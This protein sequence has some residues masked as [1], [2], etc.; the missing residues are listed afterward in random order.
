M[1]YHLYAYCNNNPVE[2]C[3]PSGYA[4]KICKDGGPKE[5]NHGDEGGRNSS[6]VVTGSG[7]GN[8]SRMMCGTQGNI[9][10]IPQ[11]VAYKLRGRCFN[12]FNEFRSAFWKEVANSTYAKEFSFG[13]IGRMQK[14]LAPRVLDTQ[15]YGGALSYVLH[16]KKPIYD[17]G[18]VYNLDNIV[19]V[20]PRV[21]Q[22]ILDKAY[23]FND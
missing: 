3:D 23:H 19:I 5:N 7:N 2:Y 9:G 4:K 15:Q 6:G 10:L 21:H 18:G 17:G 1:L 8:V 12:N 20:T 13:N 16:H 11:E 14:G 22:E